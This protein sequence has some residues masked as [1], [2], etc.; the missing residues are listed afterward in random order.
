MPNPEIKKQ[1]SF[2][3]YL[4]WPEDE[5]WEIINGEAY[6]QAA[7]TPLHQEVLGG[8]FVQLH[9]FFGGKDCKVFPAPFCVRLTDIIEVPDE[10]V[11]I[12][13]EPDITV[14]CDQSKI[15]AKGCQGVPDLIVE[16][17]SPSS[18]KRDRFEKFNLYETAGVKEYWLVEPEA[19]L[20]SAFTLLENKK[21]G[22]PEIF[23]EDGTITVNTFPGLT[24]DLSLIFPT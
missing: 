23:A 24:I 10:A 12:I 8:I 20:V 17:I 11:N 16:I 6:M 5:R 13:I 4:T 3:D 2:A 19:R 18:V 7:P 1:Y 9:N 22:R 14:V 21:Y 15:D